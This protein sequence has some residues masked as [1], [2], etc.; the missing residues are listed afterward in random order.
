MRYF[1]DTE[2]NENGNT[3]DLISIGIV[4][5]DGREYYAVS[6]SFDRIEFFNNDWLVAN[7]LPGLPI[8][9][10]RPNEPFSWRNFRGD[11]DD[12]VWQCRDRIRQAILAFVGSDPAPEFWGY[13]ADYDWV[14]FCQLFGRMIDLP[15]GFPKFCMDLKQVC[16]MLGNPQLPA[17]AGEHHALADARWNKQVY[18]FLIEYRSKLFA[19][20]N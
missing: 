2:F 8:D 18:D 5:E 3:I 9:K 1:L 14:A 6:R 13:Y 20:A 17:Q 7:V 12:P 19:P 16:A 10:E 11:W 4:A 15:R